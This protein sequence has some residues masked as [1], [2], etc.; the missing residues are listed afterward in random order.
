VPTRRFHLPDA[1]ATER[2]G[3]ALGAQ[4]APRAR[5]G[6]TLALEG[7]L[8][9]GKTSLIRALAVGLGLPAT[10]PVPSPTFVIA[11]RFRLPD[12]GS[13]EHVDAYRL[14]GVD[15]L[16]AAG[17]EEMCGSGRVTCVEW[18]GRVAGALPADRLEAELEPWLTSSGQD[19]GRRL[20]LHARGPSSAAWLATFVP[21][22]GLEIAACS[23]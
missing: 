17:L 22:P 3:R 15:E 10:T 7:E 5:A 21:P 4:L 19:T 1:A 8:G 14:R 11:Q 16:E 20:S 12:G 6:V 13:L 9:A 2:L 23:A 18:A